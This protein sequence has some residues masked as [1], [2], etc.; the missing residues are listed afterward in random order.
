[1]LLVLQSG[2]NGRVSG[3]LTPFSS[4]GVGWRRRGRISSEQTRL[5]ST[6]C[7]QFTPVLKDLVCWEAHPDLAHLQN[8]GVSSQEV[9]DSV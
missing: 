8:D 9:A 6:W 4:R 1:M 7:P 5:Q 3:S 2:R